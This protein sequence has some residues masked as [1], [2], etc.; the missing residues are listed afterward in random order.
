MAEISVRNESRGACSTKRVKHMPPF[1][2]TRQNARLYEV[3][4]ERRK[5]R[6]FV[7]LC[8]D[9]PHGPFVFH[10]VMVCFQSLHLGPSGSVI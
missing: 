7:W 4:G 1:W 8:C 6:F 10:V 9:R 5:M 2:T 3:W